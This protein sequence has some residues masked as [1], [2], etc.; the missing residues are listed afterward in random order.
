QHYFAAAWVPPEGKQ[1][2]NEVLRVSD[3]V[4]AIRTIEAAGTIQP[5]ES[6]TIHS[7]LWVGPQDQK[8][9]AELAPGLDLVVDYGFLTIISKPLFKLMTWIH[10]ALGNWGWTIVALTL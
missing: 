7:N 10:A 1:R 3:N 4:Y 5:G 9:M 8:A 2:V 6:T